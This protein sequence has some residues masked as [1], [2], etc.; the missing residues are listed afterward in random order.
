[1]NNIDQDK[2]QMKYVTKTYNLVE[3]YPSV[4]DF[5]FELASDSEILNDLHFDYNYARYLTTFKL[6]KE[7]YEHKTKELEDLG[8]LEKIKYPKSF[9]FRLVKHLWE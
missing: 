4:F 2:L 6:T 9:K 7:Q 5:L 3:G 8:Y 1:M